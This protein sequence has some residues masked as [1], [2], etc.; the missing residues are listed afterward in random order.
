MS[1]GILAGVS[2]GW[3]SAPAALVQGIGIADISLA[4]LTL[5]FL[6]GFGIDVFFRLLDRLLELLRKGVTRLGGDDDDP[7]GGVAVS[8]SRTA[9]AVPAS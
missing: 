5:A 3:F 6:V 8:T 9:P 1:L 7:K 4:T 2:V